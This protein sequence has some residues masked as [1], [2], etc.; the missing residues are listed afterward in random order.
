[1]SNE[2][3]KKKRNGWDVDPHGGTPRD[4]K[5]R[6]RGSPPEP[7]DVDFNNDDLVVWLFELARSNREVFLQVRDV[8]ERL[9]EEF[10]KRSVIP[11]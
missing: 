11:D 4:W 7:I 1:M 5:L 6:R 2:P 9:I 8:A 3:P 10:Q